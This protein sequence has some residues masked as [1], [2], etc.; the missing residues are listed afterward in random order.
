MPNSLQDR[1]KL[2]LECIYAIKEYFEPI[3]E[4][5]DFFELGSGPL[6][7]DAITMRLQVIGENAK[8]IELDNPLFFWNELNYDVG[9]LIRFRDLISNHYDRLDYEV[10]YDTC[11]RRLHKLEDVIKTFLNK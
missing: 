6:R 5:D 9:S 3:K 2:I 7:L 11:S 1:L 4:Q 10:I 8:Q